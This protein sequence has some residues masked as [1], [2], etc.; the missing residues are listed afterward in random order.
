MVIDGE[1]IISK[2]RREMLV[3]ELKRLNFALKS[4]LDAIFKENSTETE[5]DYAVDTETGR[6][7]PK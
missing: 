1:L 5:S 4:E 6:I 2:K 7:N 3:A